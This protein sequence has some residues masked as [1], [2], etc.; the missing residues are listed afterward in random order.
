MLVLPMNV[1]EALPECFQEAQGRG[2]VVDVHPVLAR[3]GHGTPDHKHVRGGMA[4][5]SEDCRQLRRIFQVDDRFHP[6]LFS[7]CPNPFRLRPFPQNELER[8]DQKA[9][10]CPG[11]AGQDVQTM[12][13]GDPG[14]L[15][16]GQVC[17]REFSK[18]PPG[19]PSANALPTSI[20]FEGLQSSP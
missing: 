1:R 2:P 6:G 20:S 12:T 7:L 14:L 8:G 19:T 16:D 17:Y 9:L 5:F 15:D 11:F 13:E 18:H 3:T 4:G 10:A